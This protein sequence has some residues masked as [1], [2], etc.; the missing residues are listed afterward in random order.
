MHFPLP[1][2]LH[3]PTLAVALA[4]VYIGSFIFAALLYAFRRSFPGA[5]LWILGQA[6]LAIGA[7]FIAIQSA[8]LPYALLVVSNTSM[9]AAAIVLGHSVWRFGLDGKF[10]RWLYLIVPASLVVWFALD[11]FGADA[12]TVAY[13]GGL[14]GI[15]GFVAAKILSKRNDEYGGLFSITAVF[16]VF[17]ALVGLARVVGVFIGSSPVTVQETGAMGGIEYFFSLLV[18]LFNLFGY[19]LLSS[20]KAERDLRVRERESW[21]RNEELVE[22][23]ETKDALI[24]VVG[25]DLRAPVWS[26]TRFVRAHLVDFEGDLNTKR[27]SIETLAEGMDRISGLLDSLLEWAL[28]A[29]GKITLQSERLSVAEVLAEAAADLTS[30]IETKGLSL[31]GPV[32]DGAII[33]DRRALATVFRNVLSN[34]IK[35]SRRGSSVRVAVAETRGDAGS[36][37]I[38]VAIEDSGVGMRPDQLAKLFVPGRTRLT[39]GTEG[40]QGK[41][42]GLAISKR[43]VETMGGELRVESELGVGTKFVLVFPVAP[44]P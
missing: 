29:S 6:I 25:H 24:A 8:G 40:E 32:G 2:S 34:A 10:P 9:L 26:A 16:F 1:I 43:F 3:Y 27:E 35:Y 22:T 4:G 12:R 18:A 38:A 30:T 41:G 15:S 19:F 28:C 21:R 39:L 36:A 31:E 42:F 23:L 33:A 7:S 11:P 14:F 44:K 13:S 37:T 17:T 5:G 20:A